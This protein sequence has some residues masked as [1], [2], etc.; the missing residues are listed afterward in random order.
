M[1]NLALELPDGTAVAADD[2]PIELL[3]ANTTL[4]NQQVRF[5]IPTPVEG[6]YGLILIDDTNDKRNA[7]SFEIV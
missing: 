3:F 4:P 2:G 7:V 6:T 5:T 1:N